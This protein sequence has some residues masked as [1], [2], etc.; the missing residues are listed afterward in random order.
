MRI[1]VDTEILKE[2]HLSLGDFL[3]LLLGFYEENYKESLANL[4][5]DGTVSPNQ[6]SL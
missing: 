1:T 3:M 4:M 6:Y 2:E 5:K